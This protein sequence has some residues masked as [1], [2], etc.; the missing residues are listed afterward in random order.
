MCSSKTRRVRSSQSV[1][2]RLEIKRIKR[3]SLTG[4]L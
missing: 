1:D 3:V 4:G 2:E